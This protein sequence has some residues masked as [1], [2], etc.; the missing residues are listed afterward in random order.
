MSCEPLPFYAGLC[1]IYSKNNG[2][3]YGQARLLLIKH[4]FSGL[5]NHLDTVTNSVCCLQDQLSLAPRQLL[6]SCLACR[7][8][9]LAILQAVVLDWSLGLARRG[10]LILSLWIFV[11]NDRF[12][13]FASESIAWYNFYPVCNRILTENEIDILSTLFLMSI[14]EI[15]DAIELCVRSSLGNTSKKHNDFEPTLTVKANQLRFRLLATIEKFANEEEETPEMANSTEHS[16]AGYFYWT[17]GLAHIVLLVSRNL[18]IGMVPVNEFIIST[19]EEPFG[20]VKES[21]LFYAG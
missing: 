21:K 2:P 6:C 5:S 3:N 10:C 13:K 18:R 16:F 14:V 1:W 20:G 4:S 19:C 7:C 15:N 11:A 17:Q 12:S 9:W 8:N